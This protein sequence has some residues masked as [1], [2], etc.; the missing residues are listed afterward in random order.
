M[1]DSFWNAICAF[2]DICVWKGSCPFGRSIIFV[3]ICALIL[4]LV[5]CQ[6]RQHELQM[7]WYQHFMVSVWQQHCKV[8]CHELGYQA[9]THGLHMTWYPGAEARMFL[10][11]PWPP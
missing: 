2:V 1:E 7:T 6:N 3:H 5:P 8:K 10:G 11:G 9:V 4:M